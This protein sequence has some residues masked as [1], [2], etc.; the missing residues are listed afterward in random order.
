VKNTTAV[1]LVFVVCLLSAPSWAQTAAP[2]IRTVTVGSPMPDFTLPSYQGGDVTLSKL[3]GKT[4]ILVFPR[5]RV[6]ENAWCH[7]DNYQHSELVDYEAAN[8][9]RKNANAEILVIFPYE[10]VSIAEW[11]DKYPQQLADIEGFKN[12]PDPAK[13]DD[14]GR[15]RMEG[16]RVAYP[17]TFKAGTGQALTPFPILFDADRTVTKGLGIFTT[18]WGGSKIDQDVPTVYVIDPAGIVRF[19][20]FSQNTLDRPGIDHLAKVVAWV[21]Q[22]AKPA[23]R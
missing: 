13:L 10:R 8:Q 12:P 17:K 18:E 19:K 16:S 15:R 21:N 22:S 5:G 23:G 4:V 6:G 11:I 9:F 14:A 20:Y 3:R 2:A 1:G 7:V